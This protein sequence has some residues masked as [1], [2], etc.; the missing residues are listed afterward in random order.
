MCTEH[1]ASKHWMVIHPLRD[2]GRAWMV[3]SEAKIG[4]VKYS[5]VTMQEEVEVSWT[6]VPYF[7]SLLAGGVQGG[8]L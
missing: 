8:N 4:S 1:S 2:E 5:A 3:D 6:N 7:S